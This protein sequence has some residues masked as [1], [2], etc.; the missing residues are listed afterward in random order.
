MPESQTQPHHFDTAYYFG[1]WREVGHYWW[2]P[3]PSQISWR[4][5]EQG[6]PTDQPW[7]HLDGKLTP[8]SHRQSEAALHHREGWTALAV[9]DYTVDSRPGSNIA[10]L[11]DATLDFDRAV[12][13][14]RAEFPQVVERVEAA[15]P[16]TE[17]ARANA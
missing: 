9:H 2:R 1:C 14:A 15:A 8:P 3:G 4:E 12:K 11:F 10:F 17:E 5:Y 7:G 13:A 6:C 16:I